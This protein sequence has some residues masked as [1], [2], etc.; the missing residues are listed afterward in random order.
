MVS[1]TRNLIN[2]LAHLGVVAGPSAQTPNPGDIVIEYHPYSKKEKRVISAEEFKASLNN[3]PE[4]TEPPDD[5]PWRPFRSREDFEFAELIH[6]A[7]LNQ[8]QIDRLIKLIRR[9][10]DTPGSFTLRN[11]KDLKDLQENA[12]KLLTPVTIYLPAA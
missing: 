9:C 2:E 6:D 7:A 8:P 11:H 1:T 12:S 4:L 10:Q 5:E 3:T